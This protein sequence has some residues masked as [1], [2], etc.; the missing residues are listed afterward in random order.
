MN[1]ENY[2]DFC[3]QFWSLKMT[4]IKSKRT[5][6][7]PCNIEKYIHEDFCAPII[8]LLLLFAFI[9]TYDLFVLWG[10]RINNDKY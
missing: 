5:N 6:F 9:L 7:N 2:F 8:A 1:Y 10:Q 3:V 4:W